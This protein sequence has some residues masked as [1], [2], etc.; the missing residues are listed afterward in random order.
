MLTTG[1]PLPARLEISVRHDD[2]GDLIP[3]TQL[4]NGKA[5]GIKESVRV[6][7]EAVKLAFL[8]RCEWLRRLSKQQCLVVHSDKGFVKTVLLEADRRVSLVA[9]GGANGGGDSCLSLE[10][11]EVRVQR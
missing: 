2:E 11:H 10:P 4:L 3:Q 1:G 6:K 7:D 5:G 9:P 8:R